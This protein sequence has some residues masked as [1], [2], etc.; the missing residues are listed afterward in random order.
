MQ[1]MMIL[2]ILPGQRRYADFRPS[3][4]ASEPRILENPLTV[5]VSLESRVE[6]GKPHVKGTLGLCIATVL[7]RARGLGGY[8]AKDSYENN[9]T[10]S[11]PNQLVA[12]EFRGSEYD[13]GKH[14]RQAVDGVAG[15][16]RS[17]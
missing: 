3:E 8:S 17:P 4:S 16:A 14:L 6:P 7:R 1:L 9:D 2:S 10:E 15:S 13:P 11:N 12:E 5:A